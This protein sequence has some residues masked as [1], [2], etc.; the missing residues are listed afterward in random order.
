MFTIG[1]TLKRT[2]HIFLRIVWTLLLLY[3]A[4]LLALQLPPVQRWMGRIAADALADALHTSVSIERV[5]VGLFNRIVAEGVRID[6]RQRKPLLTAQRVAGKVD[7]GQLLKGK[8]DITSLQLINPDIRLYKKDLHTP[9]NY[10]FVL[11]ALA[12]KDGKQPGASIR[13]A[14]AVVSN[15]RLR[16]DLLS[17]PRQHGGLDA[18]HL[19]LDSLQAYIRVERIAEGQ[20]IVDVR[21]LA[22]RE[23]CGLTLQHLATRLTW[24]PRHM[25]A[26]A[27]TLQLPQSC[28]TIARIQ[29]SARTTTLEQL[30]GTLTPTDIHPLLRQTLPF[31]QQVNIA[32][33]LTANPTEVAWQEMSVAT[34]DNALQLRCSGRMQTGTG[35]SGAYITINM[36][37][38]DAGMTTTLVAALR[39]LNPTLPPALQQLGSL[40]AQ[41][42]FRTASGLLSAEGQLTCQLGH[43]QGEIRRDARQTQ[44][45]ITARQLTL[46]SFMP[47]KSRLVLTG[48]LS[49]V[50]SHGTPSVM[51]LKGN[52][53][54]LQYQQ[55]TLSHI[56][57]DGQL[58]RQGY[59]GM[60]AV[61]DSRGSLHANGKIVLAPDATQATLTAQVRHLSS[62]LLMPRQKGVPHTTLDMDVQIALAG[63][64]LH[65]MTGTLTLNNIAIRK[66]NAETYTIPHINIAATHN[67]NERQLTLHSPFADVN[68]HGQYNPLT[69]ADAVGH[70]LAQ[71]M[72]AFFHAKYATQHTDEVNCKLSMQLYDTEW[73]GKLTGIDL[74]TEAPIH[75]E[76]LLDAPCRQ[77]DL[78]CNMPA[79]R[80]NGTQYQHTTLNLN[81]HAD[82]LHLQAQTH[83]IADNGQQ[84]FDISLQGQAYD[85]TFVSTLH[86]DNHNEKRHLSGE[87]VSTVQLFRNPQRQPVTHISLNPSTIYINGEAWNVQPSDIVY[88][89]RQLIV[90]HFAV[91][92]GRQHITASGIATEDPDSKIDIQFEGV[93]FDL[94]TDLLKTKGVEF[95]GQADGTAQIS[96]LFLQPKA[97]A[98]LTIHDFSFTQAHLG[99]FNLQANWS[100]ND[101]TIDLN[102]QCVE[103]V[104][105][106]DILNTQLST[107]TLN[108]SIQLKPI[109]LNL[110]IGVNNSPTRFMEVY[111]P[112]LIQHMDARATGGIRVFGPAKHVD[113]EG[114]IT[115]DGNMK[116]LPLQTTYTLHGDTILF[117]P[118]HIAFRNI[119]FTDHRQQPLHMQGDIAHS[120]LKNWNYHFRMD[121]YN[122]CL[123]NRPGFEG[124][125]FCGTIYADA[126]MEIDGRK[127][128][129]S[130]NLNV[131]P[132][133]HSIIEYNASQPESTHARE[134]IRWN[135]STPD[136]QTDALPRNS[137]P[138]LSRPVVAT[139]GN[140]R[141]NMVLNA[142]P[143]L[144]LRVVLND[145]NDDRIDLKGNGILRASYFN[146]GGFNI[147][148]NYLVSGGNYRMTIQN[149]LTRLFTFHEGGTIVFA[150]N[151]Y[152]AQLNLQATHTVNGVSLA[153]LQI[154]NS[155]KAN[156]IKVN[157]LMNL[158]GTPNTPQV[159]F[160]I[161]M[162]S[163]GTDAVQ[164]V[165]SIINSE[166]ELNQQ[167][168]YLLTIGRFYNAQNNATAQSANAQSQT[169]L[170]MQSLLSGT[171]SQQ[172]NNLLSNVLHTNNNWTIGA[173]I[174]TGND[175][176]NNA[177]YEGLLSGRLLNNRL[178]INGQFG[179]RD[180][181]NATTSFIGDFDV[182]YLLYPNGNLAV[183]VYNQTNDRY[184]TRNSLNT[185]GIGLIL[186]KDFNTAADLFR[187]RKSKKKEKTDTVRKDTVHFSLPL[188]TD[189]TLHKK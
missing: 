47:D 130:I 9:A 10:Q 92:N 182:R 158:K 24:T 20:G 31:R 51:T 150:G 151:P 58:H 167:V 119:N 114:M 64:V 52:V 101:N 35:Q 154:G 102:G 78:S 124:N 7:V 53:D 137:L 142:T 177:E 65:D 27:T 183:R 50:A 185:Q 128:E 86:F 61:N 91:R 139:A 70:V 172:L 180:N 19:R 93:D 82:T 14:S 25:Q 189:T 8:V 145:D 129:T 54:Q 132:R 28:L 168:I 83:R 165:R 178:L 179:Y 4:L 99:Q 26:T 11:D 66:T 140:M 57:L 22:F 138:E 143:D 43:V 120:Y 127:G 131:T 125:T 72:P 37:K 149:M 88:Q 169:S 67:G 6:D 75:I 176:W 161:D 115:V 41:G 62:A 17:Q 89:P 136:S 39:Q 155:F 186:K 95:G 34:A 116:I 32:A 187:S 60:L 45:D 134:F 97:S 175:G 38:A 153:D 44:G 85:S 162:P 152:D 74:Q 156:N 123:L 56:T 15:G 46:T 2:A 112:T 107:T 147:Y 76:G 71:R 81:T 184:F 188:P 141:L 90:D 122:A 30:Q 144:T 159:D 5:E 69:L 108:G 18:S 100:S 98:Q 3:G 94:L 113:I 135:N 164:M 126:G 21:N 29:R 80:Y 173:N 79:L 23:Q 133:E 63:N 106:D 68:L 160:D 166:E 181:P 77:L 33:T 110:N 103:T 171:V 174:S 117:N 42:H 40:T 84:P 146:K 36:L 170:A 16:Y 1:N 109:N 49:F 13:I 105:T 104:A 59:E 48:Q 163:A 73:L 121:A 111:V 118:G 55:H 148:G 87:V 157:C 96:S 12:P